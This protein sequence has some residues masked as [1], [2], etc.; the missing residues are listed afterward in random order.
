MKLKKIYAFLSLFKIHCHFI[1][2]QDGTEQKQQEKVLE[3]AEALKAIQGNVSALKFE[4]IWSI[5][6]SD[7]EDNVNDVPKV[8][9]DFL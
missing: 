9:T 8:I 1:E 7:D 6:N 5:L 4:R 2:K 3:V